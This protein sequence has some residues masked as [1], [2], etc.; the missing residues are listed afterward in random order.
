MKKEDFKIIYFA[1]VQG[2]LQIVA[3]FVLGGTGYFIFLKILFP[4]VLLD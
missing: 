1:L 3:F 4:K 2:T